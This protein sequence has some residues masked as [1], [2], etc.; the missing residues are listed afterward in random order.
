M[1]ARLCADAEEREKRLE[2]RLLA[3]DAI[4]TEQVE[5]AKWDL[6]QCEDLAVMMRARREE[7]G[8]VKRGVEGI[9]AEI[10][11]MRALGGPPTLAGATV[12]VTA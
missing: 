12:R 7:L 6:K 9:A 11:G 2:V 8:E 10:R 1:V 4:E 5:K 3:L